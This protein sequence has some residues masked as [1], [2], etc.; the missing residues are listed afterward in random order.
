[1][2]IWWESE[3][4]ISKYTKLSCKYSPNFMCSICTELCVRQR[5]IYLENKTI[6]TTE[7]IFDHIES[8]KCYSISYHL[9]KFGKIKG[10]VFVHFL[11]KII[12]SPKVRGSQRS[13]LLSSMSTI[14]RT[15]YLNRWCFVLVTPNIGKSCG[16][17]YKCRLPIRVSLMVNNADNIMYGTLTFITIQR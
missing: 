9:S 5:N 8:Y 14:V 2:I 7:S 10:A 17:N 6:K 13:R 15:C 12:V 1:M 3:W 4:N 11:F 16:N